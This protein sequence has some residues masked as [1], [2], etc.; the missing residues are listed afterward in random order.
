MG[1]EEFLKQEEERFIRDN[2]MTDEMFDYNMT[3]I[4]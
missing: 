3:E 4:L 2:L 1:V